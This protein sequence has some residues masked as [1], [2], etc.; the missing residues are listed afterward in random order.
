MNRFDGLLRWS[1]SILVVFTLAFTLGGCD[2]DDGID[3]TN[4]ANGADGADGLPGTPAPIPDPI[5]AAIDEAQVE[6]CATCHGGVGDGHQALYNRYTDGSADAGTNLTLALTGFTSA[7]AAAGGFDVELTIEITRNG[8]PLANIGD[9]GMT[10]RFYITRYD[11]AAGQYFDGNQRIRNVAPTGTPGEF[12]VTG[13]ISFNP[14][15]AVNPDVQFYGYVGDEQVIID[16]VNYAA[17]MGLYDN[18]ASASLATGV[19]GTDYES[20]ANASGCENCHGAPYMKHGNRRAAVEGLPEFAACKSCHY[21]DRNGGHTDWQYM[22]D[23]PLNWANGV[24]ET[25]DYSYV[26]N[27]MNDTHM[28]HA[29]EFPYPQSMANCATCHEGK[30]D[31]VLAD[32]NFTAETCMSCH[33]AQGIDAWPKTYDALGDEILDDGDSVPGIYY[34]SHR[35]PPMAYLWKDANVDGFAFHNPTEDCTNCHKAEID[36]G[37]ASL[38]TDLHTGYDTRISNDAGV[39]YDSIYT[40]SID[41]ITMLDDTLTIDFSTSDAAIQPEIL[42]SFYG[43]GSKQFLIASHSRDASDVCLSRSGNPGSGCRMEFA[44]GDFNPLFSE[45]PGSVTLDM[46]AYVPTVTLPDT[47]PTLIGNNVIRMA[48]VT[49]TGEMVLDGVEL[50]LDAVTQTFDVQAGGSV[51]EY[52]KGDNATVDTDKCDA[53]HDQL[54][55]TFHG[56]S[57]RGGDI[58]ACKNCHVVTSPG[59]HLEM[60]SRAIDSYVHAIHTFQPFDLGDVD[61]ANPVEVKRTAMHEEHTFPNFTITNCEGCH[62]EGTYNVPDQSQSMPGLLAKSDTIADRNIGAIPEAVTGPAS[63]AC[64]GCHRAELINE[65]KAGELASFNAH[66][67][68]FGTY[69]ENDTADDQ[70]TPVDDEYLFGI[71]DKIM[72]WFE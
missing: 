67:E 54:A 19:A 70:G 18:L 17:H 55:V 64:G 8:Q 41:D 29:M 4:G 51:D 68:A 71:I 35:A 36:G 23:E 9:L 57:G 46:A 44:P 6:S 5:L 39:R 43:W 14:D 40:V 1:L 12:I 16:D 47:I 49:V 27:V 38:F 28:S 26:A 34:Q 2:G 15:P 61:A 45:V 10:N 3:G 7:A 21:D 30:V 60:A 37:F 31:V 58:V 59:S 53:C 24:A 13:N 72:T 48:E 69:V 11:S 25:A 66:T 22:V 32:E 52:F 42:V 33:A 63:R 56:G 50:A 62:V 20:A 65:D